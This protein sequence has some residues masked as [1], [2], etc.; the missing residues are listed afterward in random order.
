MDV[1]QTM[2]RWEAIKAEAAEPEPSG[3]VVIDEIIARECIRA[4]IC[5]VMQWNPEGPLGFRLSEQALF[6]LGI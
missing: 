6:T 4:Q 3:N 5:E 1:Q 2:N